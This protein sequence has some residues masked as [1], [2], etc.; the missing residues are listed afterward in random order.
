MI[1]RFLVTDK[2]TKVSIL[3]IKLSTFY[4]WTSPDNLYTMKYWFHYGLLQILDMVCV[5]QDVTSTDKS[6]SRWC[7]IESVRRELNM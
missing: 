6:A 5:F 1:N 3:I 7:A 2:M 4:R